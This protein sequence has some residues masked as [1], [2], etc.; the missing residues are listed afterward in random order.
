[1]AVVDSIRDRME[2]GF[3]RPSSRA[4]HDR[5]L[6]SLRHEHLGAATSRPARSRSSGFEVPSPSLTSRSALSTPCRARTCRPTSTACPA[7]RRPG[8]AGRACRSRPSTGR[9]SSRPSRRTSSSPTWCSVATTASGPCS[10]SRTRWPTTCSSRT[11]STASR[12]GETTVRW[13]GSGFGPRQYGYVSTK[14]LCRIDVHTSEPT[15]VQRSWALRVLA[16]HPRA[17]VAEEE[18]H[19]YVPAG[20]PACLPFPDASAAASEPGGLVASGCEARNRRR[21]SQR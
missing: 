21:H 14:H 1:M 13:R 12:S 2:P 8:S 17:R 5:R 7:G 10:R 19:R 16:P 20:A 11:T 6:P 4:G 3:R 9:T 15:H 18:R